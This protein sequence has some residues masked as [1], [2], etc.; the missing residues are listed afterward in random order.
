MSAAG[1]VSDC[2]YSAASERLVSRVVLFSSNLFRQFE[3]A[4]N[5]AILAS[6]IGAAE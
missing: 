5:V 3:S 2:V 6:F 1:A 4:H